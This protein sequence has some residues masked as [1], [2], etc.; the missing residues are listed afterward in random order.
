VLA[1]TGLWAATLT[2]DTS[3]YVGLLPGIALS[4]MCTS[5]ARHL[6]GG[7][8]S[9]A[10]IPMTALVLFLPL[11]L[12]ASAPAL[13]LGADLVQLLL[14]L[15]PALIA[16]L[17]GVM[18]GWLAWYGAVEP[19]PE[20]I[21]AK[22]AEEAA[23]AGP[24]VTWPCGICGGAVTPQMKADCVFGCGQVFHVGCYSTR[25]DLSE[26]GMCAVCGYRPA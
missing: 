3:W 20:R 7:L 16:G 4:L 12:L 13:L 11:M 25:Q 23:A 6:W 10:K 17:F 18:L 1:W 24:V 21:T 9:Q 8:G 5:L 14:I 2:V 19:L 26:R 22:Q 15:A